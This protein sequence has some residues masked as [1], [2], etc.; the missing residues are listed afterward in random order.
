MDCS[1]EEEG[2]G[3][4][5]L[6]QYPMEVIS[7]EAWRCWNIVLHRE[8]GFESRK[9]AA[10][11]LLDLAEEGDGWAQYA[12]GWLYEDGGVFPFNTKKAVQYYDS[13][14]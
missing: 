2:L 11:E 3:E 10:E 4:E 9:G 13:A 5:E 7:E 1:F 8:Y 12:C 6:G 14:A